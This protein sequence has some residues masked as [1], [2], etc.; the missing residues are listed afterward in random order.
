MHPFKGQQGPSGAAGI[1]QVLPV[2]V[3]QLIQHSFVATMLM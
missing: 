3:M 2:S 1:R